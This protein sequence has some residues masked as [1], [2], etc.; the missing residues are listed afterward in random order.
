MDKSTLSAPYAALLE[1]ATPARRAAYFRR[2]N[3]AVGVE[4][5]FSVM[6]CFLDGQVLDTLAATTE[7]LLRLL[8]APAYQQRVAATPWV[9][10]QAPISAA[11][12]HGAMDFHITEQGGKLIEVNFSPPGFLGFN[13]LAEAALFETFDLDPAGQVNRDFEETL[14]NAVCDA[15]RAERVAIA[16]NHTAVSEYF[17][18]HYRY[19]EKIFRNHGADADMV[20][21]NDVE[22]A[23]GALPRWQGKS[24]ERVFNLVIPRLMEHWP[25]E[26]ARFIDL[27]HRQ[28]G[29]ITPNPFGWRLGSKA[30]LS[31]CHGLD[32]ADFGIAAV[33][34]DLIRAT[35]LEA[36]LLADFAT[37]EAVVERF[38][39][40]HHLVLKPLDDY[41]TRSVFIQPDPATLREVFATRRADYVAQ[42]FH[43]HPVH[44]FLTAEGELK[45][46]L[47]CLRVGFVAGRVCGIRARSFDRT[48]AE[49]Y[50]APVVRI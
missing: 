18:P 5:P 27:Y 49:C 13:R 29:R 47:L 39:A 12:C 14:V 11:D 41:D 42:A 24:Y 20:F 45:P 34:R 30:F 31:V 21:G 16:C 9:L 33:D 1:Q 26:F 43:R 23:D 46:H 3:E 50:M 8:M 6:P 22:L 7:A 36:Y 2:L 4:Y 37:P 17:R 48:A 35:A 10:P 25:A 38:G 28:A 15:T 44:P 40:L 32:A 19:V